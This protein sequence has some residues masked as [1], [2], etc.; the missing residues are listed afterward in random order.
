MGRLQEHQAMELG[1]DDALQLVA[2]HLDAEHWMDG[3][4]LAVGAVVPMFSAGEQTPVMLA[5]R[6]GEQW[7]VLVWD[8]ARDFMRGDTASD[9]PRHDQRFAVSWPGEVKRRG[10]RRAIQR[11]GRKRR[12]AAASTTFALPNWWW[13]RLDELAQEMGLFKDIKNRGQTKALRWLLQEGI[14]ERSCQLRL[15]AHHAII[16]PAATGWRV[17]ALRIEGYAPADGSLADARVLGE[18]P[19]RRHAWRA[20]MLAVSHGSM[21]APWPVQGTD[22]PARDF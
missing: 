6:E 15:P 3:R 16:V 7:T 11:P 4:D 5:R 17:L 1:R 14:I 12:P 10:T 13:R 20:A 8:D 21:V 2:E 18:G 22:W 19:T 9:R